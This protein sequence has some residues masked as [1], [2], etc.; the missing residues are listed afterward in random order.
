MDEISAELRNRN[1]KT[2]AKQS[3]KLL[4]IDKNNL[5]ALEALSQAKWHRGDYCGA[6]ELGAK[7]IAVNPFEPGYCVLQAMCHMMLGRYTAA[8][9]AFEK[10][11]QKTT[12]SEFQNTLDMQALDAETMLWMA[13]E[14]LKTVDAQFGREFS[15]NPRA[16]CLKAGLPLP[17]AT[18]TSK[19]IH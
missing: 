18:A 4:K 15:R 3:E 19:G 13:V 1:W 7:L 17:A 12:R 9:D 11:R 2:V 8:V 16:A 6:F 10:A 14:K 5:V